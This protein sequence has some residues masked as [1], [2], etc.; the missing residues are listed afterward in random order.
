MEQNPGKTNPRYNAI[1]FPSPLA[2]RYI[3]DSLH[4]LHF[5]CIIYVQFMYNLPVM[6]VHKP[7]MSYEDRQAY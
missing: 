5:H 6:Q 7:W 2:L 4:L 1:H 3:R